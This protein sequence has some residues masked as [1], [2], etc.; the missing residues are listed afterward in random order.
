LHFIE[1]RQ[2][3]ADGAREAR[4]AMDDHRAAGVEARPVRLLTL[5]CG[6]RR[7]PIVAFGPDSC[8]VEMPA[9]GVM[10]RGVVD[11]WDGERHMIHGLI[12]LAAPEWP[13]QRCYFKLRTAPRASPAPDFAPPAPGE[14]GGVYD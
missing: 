11:V 8:L 4:Q 5:E 1:R 6:S 7:Y 9:D 10:P 13:Y 3:F 14:S 12:V 2:S